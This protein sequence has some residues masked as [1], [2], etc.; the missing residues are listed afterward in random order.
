MKKSSS[1]HLLWNFYDVSSNIKTCR[2][3]SWAV[4]SRPKLVIIY[5][6]KRYIFVIFL[7]ARFYFF[8]FV[9]LLKLRNHVMSKKKKGF[10]TLG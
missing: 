8:F 2:L 10:T 1:D 9:S 4:A 5:R 7:T 3:V 6:E